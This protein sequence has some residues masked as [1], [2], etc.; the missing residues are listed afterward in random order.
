MRELGRVESEG[1]LTMKFEGQLEPKKDWSMPH[2][3][4]YGTVEKITQG[5]DKKFGGSDGYTF[6]SNPISCAS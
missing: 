2:L 4:V 3:L 1:V 5:C 6:Q